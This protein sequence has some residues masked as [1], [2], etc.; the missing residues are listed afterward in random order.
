MQNLPHLN[1]SNKRT[2]VRWI[3]RLPRMWFTSFNVNDNRSFTFQDQTKQLVKG[4][5][6]SRNGHEYK[7]KLLARVVMFVTKRGLISF[8]PMPR[9]DS[10]QLT[11]KIIRVFRGVKPT[12]SSLTSLSLTIVPTIPAPYTGWT[13]LTLI[14]CKIVLFVLK[15]PKINEKE[16]RLAFFK[17]SCGKFTN[18]V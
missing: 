10:I 16:A 14:C 9:Y 18:I 1:V 5:P 13:I 3:Q 15:R 6:H 4:E 2:R 7:I 11:R 12:T 17:N 8:V